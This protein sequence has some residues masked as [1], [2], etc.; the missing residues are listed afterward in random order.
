MQQYDLFPLPPV[1]STRQQ[2]ERRLLMTLLRQAA[3]PVLV[4]ATGMTRRQID[5]LMRPLPPLTLP[6]AGPA[7]KRRKRR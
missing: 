6:K 4:G 1:P 3:R 5:L 2:R 7:G